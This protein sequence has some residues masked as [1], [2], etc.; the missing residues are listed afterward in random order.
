[1]KFFNTEITSVNNKIVIKKESKRRTRLN[2]PAKARRKL[3]HRL[4]SPNSDG[5]FFYHDVDA[6]ADLQVL[7]DKFNMKARGIG[8][9]PIY[10]R[11]ESV[12][13]TYQI[14]ISR[15]GY[16]LWEEFKTIELP[17]T[18]LLD[19]QFSF[20]QET[21]L[22]E[23]QVEVGKDIYALAENFNRMFDCRTNFK[24][25]FNKDINRRVI[26]ISDEHFRIW[27]NL[28]CNRQVSSVDSVQST[29]DHQTVPPMPMSHFVSEFKLENN[30]I[31]PS[32]SIIDFESDPVLKYFSN[33][34]LPQVALEIFTAQAASNYPSV[35]TIPEQNNFINDSESL[36]S[37]NNNST[38]EIYDQLEEPEAIETLLQIAYSFIEN[39][40]QGEEP[41]NAKRKSAP[42]V[43]LLRRKFLPSNYENY[44]ECN[45]H[46]KKR[47]TTLAMQFRNEAA[48]L[49]IDNIKF[50]S[51]AG[52]VL[53][54]KDDYSNYWQPAMD[55]YEILTSLNGFIETD[56]GYQYFLKEGQDSIKIHAFLNNKLAR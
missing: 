25:Q 42:Y 11:F 51:A 7:T 3:R 8:C 20:N 12:P 32:Q 40:N 28:L 43:P 22:W 31:N 38:T 23:H 18:R 36:M 54:S 26:T 44:L 14:K 19:R 50:T 9:N 1:M 56:T 47:A 46:D 48:N 2:P 24:I 49:G 34:K 41:L 10:V 37:N 27:Q 29:Y 45:I 15:E 13:E 30:N 33:I 52:A 21:M 39:E 17:K 55:A 53:I 5:S 16:E 6:L 35:E 4:F